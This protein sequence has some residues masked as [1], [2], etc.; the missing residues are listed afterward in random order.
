MAIYFGGFYGIAGIFKDS[1]FYKNICVNSVIFIFPKIFVDSMDCFGLCPR[2]DDKLAMES[3]ESFV[4]STE[5]FLRFCTFAKN[6]YF[7]WNL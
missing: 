1:A 6:L 2:N 4:D 5:S 3:L 7:L